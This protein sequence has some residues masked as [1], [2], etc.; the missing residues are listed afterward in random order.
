ML[1]AARGHP[2]L[3][4]LA[5]GQAA[6]PAQLAAL[7]AAGDHAWRERG[8]LPL[9]FFATGE[10]TAP[11]SGSAAVAADYRHV[12]ATW[13][14]S[15]TDTLAPGERDLFWFLCC[16][17]EPDRQRW[18]LGANWADLWQRLGRDGEPPNLDQALTVISATSLIT[19]RSVT[20]R[21]DETYQVH[22]GVAE[23]GRGHAGQPFR[24][25]AD[26]LAAGFW[27]AVH[28]RASGQASGGSVDTGLLVR[29]GLAAIPYL[30]RQRQWDHAARLIE[31]AFVRDPSRANAAAVLPA[32]EQ[33]TRREPVWAGVLARV[34]AVTDPDAAVTRLRAA[35]ADAATR[36]DY[37][38]A[39]ANAGRLLDLC[40]NT[41]RLAEALDA[42]EQKAG[43][44]RQAGLGPWDQLAN[45]VWR[46]QVLATMG[47]ANQVL[48]EVTRLRA[49]M[50]TLPATP[51]P[52][53]GEAPWHVREA[54]L[55]T[56]RYAAMLLGRHDDVLP[57]IAEVTAS[58][59][60]RQAPAT[61]IARTRYNNYFPLLHLGRTEEAL[62]V[63]RDCRQVF[64]DARDTLM[65]GRTLSALADVE[66][67]RGHGDA[68]LRLERDSLRYKYL[69]GDVEGIAIGY[70]N[71][72]NH[73]AGHAR[74]PA[75]A[76]VSHL[77]SAFVCTLI[78]NDDVAESV[79]A[80]AT[81]LRGFGADDVPPANV[82]DLCRQ[83]GDIPG[84]DLPGLIEQLCPDPETAEQALRDLIAQAQELATESPADASPGPTS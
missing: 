78:G 72:G 82:A 35:M 53:E 40:R 19:M 84:T 15:V 70:H 2:K 51:G 33:I 55:D 48:D 71:L 64:Q 80:A 69:A 42:A 26:T 10:G 31:A 66:D 45:E 8:G 46:L 30:L 18:V 7:V 39:S 3:L 24:D 22:P 9:G 13:T 38:A 62:V 44:T 34:V 5:D 57:L 27:D 81:D 83:V 76:F 14:R 21:T 61:I 54:L 12:L 49:R 68:A 50:A 52:D 65:L 4:E 63:L 59:R 77:T 67:V 11:E 43:Y 56:G 29:A 36:G 47:H 37:R 73:L 41:G 1:N 60:D 74:Q 20:G 79:E 32:I 6:H 75:P 23:A 58:Q 16:L 28:Q 17:E 25:A